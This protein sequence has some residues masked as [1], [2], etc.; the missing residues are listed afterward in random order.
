MCEYACSYACLCVLTAHAMWLCEDPGSGQ[1]WLSSILSLQPTRKM[2]QKEDT[3]QTKGTKLFVG[4]FCI[5]ILFSQFSLR[6]KSLP[7]MWIYGYSI[8]FKMKLIFKLYVNEF[9]NILTKHFCSETRYY[10][11][12][13]IV[14]KG[15]FHSQKYTRP[16]MHTHSRNSSST[17]SLHSFKLKIQL[18]LTAEVLEL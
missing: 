3:C 9:M 1:S 10:T 18:S 6:A 5:N 14:S 12:W 17:M 11:T 15:S 7:E 2:A 4:L 8:N 16:H 13:D